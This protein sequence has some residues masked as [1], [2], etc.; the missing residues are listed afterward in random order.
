[1]QFTPH[2]QKTFKRA[3][4]LPVI[5]FA[6]GFA[7]VFMLT[8]NYTSLHNN[9]TFTQSPSSFSGDDLYFSIGPTGQPQYGETVEWNVF[10][11][12]N[13]EARF[14]H[15]KKGD[16]G[17]AAIENYHQNISFTGAE[18]FDPQ[19]NQD[20]DMNEQWIKVETS[21]NF[22][23]SSYNIVVIAFT[24]HND[25]EISNG[26]ID[27]SFP[28]CANLDFQELKIY[29]DW[30]EPNY[31]QSN[32]LN[33]QS[34]VF[35]F[36]Y[37]DLKPD[38]I[39][40]I[41][42]YMSIGGRNSKEK[43]TVSQFDITANMV[44]FG[45]DNL[46]S[47]VNPIPHDPNAMY[48]MNTYYQGAF[49]QCYDLIDY[50]NMYQECL[51]NNIS[52]FG[53]ED[54]SCD[55]DILHEPKEPT[56]DIDYKFENKSCYIIEYPYCHLNSEDLYYRV[57]CFNDGAGLA[58]DV[59]I[60]SD[61]EHPTWE[62]FEHLAYKLFQTTNYPL[63]NVDESYWYPNLKFGLKDIYLPGLDDQDTVRMYSECSTSINYKATTLC[64]INEVILA[65]SNI[66]F[67]DVN[68]NAQQ[69]IYTNQVNAVP[70]E[71]LNDWD[72]CASCSDD[73][74]SERRNDDIQICKIEI[75]NVNGQHIHTVESTRPYENK[76]EDYFSPTF[77]AGV[78]FIRISENGKI[79]TVKYFHSRQ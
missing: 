19:N 21:W 71:P 26:S 10:S 33:T 39:R 45:A 4:L 47:L 52:W 23:P 75:F 55:K 51:N 18:V 20:M 62:P 67:T 61:F 11:G 32:N 14:Y 57:S 13:A 8:V 12:T 77:D 38:E 2:I 48:L 31:T 17:Y 36:E 37:E 35:T 15:L 46:T 40:Y 29:N 43:N 50:P 54:T 76:M 9:Y 30:I 78:Y 28:F 70:Y 49:T 16:F 1:M 3:I 56:W 5:F 7:K 22:A 34:E 24:N 63:M 58:K 65:H 69:P 64:D 68:N 53:M 74:K 44:G 42:M 73:Q 25:T 27:V 41:Y 6:F 79:K 72:Y 66:V 59:I 60:Q